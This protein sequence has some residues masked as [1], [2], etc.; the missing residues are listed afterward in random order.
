[1]S[2]VQAGFKPRTF[3]TPDDV[4]GYLSGLSTV[5]TREPGQMDRMLA[6]LRAAN[7]AAR[8]GKSSP[9]TQQLDAVMS[10]LPDDITV[11]RQVPAGKFGNAKP[12]D[13]KGMLVN[14]AGY[15]P[16]TVAPPKPVPGTVDLEVDVPAGTKAAVAPDSSQVVLARETAMAVTEVESR[17]DGGTTMHLVAV[18]DQTATN[19]APPAAPTP[20]PA[21]GTAPAKKT[22]SFADIAAAAKKA[23]PKKTPPPAAAAPNPL[24]VPA[25]T[26]AKA[27][28]VTP[29]KKAAAAKA[30][31]TKK[32]T[33]KT[34]PPKKTTAKKAPPAKKATS[35]SFDRRVSQALTGNQARHSTASVEDPSRPPPLSI[36]ERQSLN[37]YRGNDYVQIN[38]R[39]RSGATI[40]PLADD[41]EDD[42]PDAVDYWIGNI[43]SAMQRA[44]LPNEV[45]AWRGAMDASRLFGD[46]VN[47]NLTGLEWD[48]AAY[49]STS[50]DRSVSHDFAS[51]ALSD[52]GTAANPVLMRVVVPAG[53][54][55]VELSDEYYESELLLQRGLRMRVVADRGR[56][57]QGIR[58]IDVEVVPRGR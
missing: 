3:R 38:Q 57:P 8:A 48:E 36:P 7:M 58:L 42:G 52:E 45:A 25:K 24:P 33:K 50:T 13:L 15:F 11:Y 12:Q 31:P 28:S 41:E 10:P 32:A 43:D 19:A 44:A 29:A 14:D 5:K 9:E 34:A 22:L 49:I 18:P 54:G 55:A 20:T 17:P 35:A 1:M 51:G 30:T 16:A 4:H 40:Q 47:G 56:D 39:L 46:R 53:V 21:T 23:Q 37:S 2:K 26:V 27:P 6:Q